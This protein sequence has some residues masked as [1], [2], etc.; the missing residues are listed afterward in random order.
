MILEEQVDYFEDTIKGLKPRFMSA[1]E[2]NS[3]LSKA[4]FFIN[5]AETDMSI[6]F[7]IYKA[8]VD[9]SINIQDYAQSV[10]A[11]LSKSIQVRLFYLTALYLLKPSLNL[12]CFKNLY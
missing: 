5:T 6:G 11:E 3:S 2:L 1:G 12:T 8:K 4:L 10:L 7:E 9:E